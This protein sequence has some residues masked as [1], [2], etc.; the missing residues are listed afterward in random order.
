MS[1]GV[2]IVG[3]R[4]VDLYCQDGFGDDDRLQTVIRAI[5]GRTAVLSRRLE[6]RPKKS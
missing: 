2:K 1:L 5:Q 6:L 4:R 3:H